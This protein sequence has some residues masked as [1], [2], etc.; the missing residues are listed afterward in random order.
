MYGITIP[1]I[2]EAEV[3]PGWF[4]GTTVNGMSLIAKAGPS[5]LRKRLPVL[6]TRR[7]G[8]DLVGRIP[9]EL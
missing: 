9:R 3:Q 1:T 7:R 6:V 8:V 2:F 5:V 4:K